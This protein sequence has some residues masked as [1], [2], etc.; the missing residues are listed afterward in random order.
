MKKI[1]TMSRRDLLKRTSATVIAGGL[2]WGLPRRARAAAA[3]R[4]MTFVEGTDITVLD[5]MM[6]T[7][8]PSNGPNLLIYDGLVAFDKD[9]KI[10]PVLA[11]KWSISPDQK[12]W[13]FN[14]R[15]NVKFSNGAAFNAKSIQF[16][17]ERMMD[18]GT[19]SPARSQYVA[20]ER[21]EAPDDLTVKFV[22]KAPFPDLLRNLGQPNFLAYDPAH[23][24]R[25]SI[26]DYARNPIGT[27]PF[28]LKEWVS[29]DRAVFV[30][31]PHYWGA[32]PRVSS[33]IYKPI[34][35]GA[36]RAAMLRTGEADI[37]VKIPPEEI[38]NLERDPGVNVL[39]LDSMY[40]IS[41]ELNN[42]MENPPLNKKLV[43][44]ALNYA[45]DKEAIVK[46][47]LMGL[48]APMVSPFGPGINF[49]ATSEPYRYDPARAKKLLADAGYPNGFKLILN[50]PNGRYLKDKEVTEAVQ[51]YLRAVGIQ[52]EV[53]VWEWSPYQVMLQKDE[54]REAFM[55]GRATPS[56]DFTATRLFSKG[57]IGL[58]NV[59]GFWREKVEELLV[60]GRS[61]FD[62]KE[63]TECY[64]QIQA[65]VWEEAP[66]VFLHNQKAVVGLRK[67]V[68]G[69][70]MLP[71]EVNLLANVHKA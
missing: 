48:G 4:D 3:K 23:T 29:G 27:G 62:E 1:G 71:T 40:Q 49:R 42:M 69:Y 10:V 43:R 5:P 58:Y 17:F 24:K 66:W 59:T 63:R 44:Q 35:E 15:P 41:Y 30:P 2:A 55:V 33:I 50:T 16:T 6:V 57:A 65:I 28:V 22:T 54:K 25:F 51:G 45:V 53:K 18:E 34:P 38:A 52:A 47:V 9:M 31:N 36:A 70:A 26:R 61:S 32:A 68:E 11:T 37:A 46:S 67:G 20:V 13:T 56:A 64:R 8:T 7:D 19:A 14:L 21:V 39:K 12:T 60:K